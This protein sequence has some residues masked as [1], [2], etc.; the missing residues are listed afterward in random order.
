M[1]IKK[2]RYAEKL[3]AQVIVAISSQILHVGFEYF[4]KQKFIK[5]F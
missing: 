4:L 3:F 1:I 2:M 5:F